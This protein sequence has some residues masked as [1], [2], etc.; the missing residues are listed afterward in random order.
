MGSPSTT[1]WIPTILLARNFIPAQ[2][3]PRCR[4]ATIP[5]VERYT[6]YT[7]G[8]IAHTV[9]RMR[10]LVHPDRRSLDALLVSPRVERITWE[11]AQKLEYRPVS[12]GERFG[13]VWA[14]F[15]FRLQARVPPEWA[16][17]QVDLIWMT[18]NESLL[19]LDGRAAQGLVDAGG[20][21]RPVATL[22]DRANGAER[23]D[24]QIELACNW[25]AGEP[26]SRRPFTEPRLERA[27]I[28]R[29]DHDAWNLLHDFRT[30]Q[31]LEADF[32]RGLDPAW[33]GELLAE[34]NRFCN[35]W[36]ADDRETWPQA[37]AILEQ[38]LQRRNGTSAHQV[39]AIGHGHLDTAWLW[40]LAETYRKS[41]RT[42]ST[43]LALMRSHPEH[44]F[45]S[46]AAQHYDWVKERN[47]G[48]YRRIVD[49]V[50]QGRWVPVG[51]T[52]I[53]PDCNIPSGESLVRQFLHGQRYFEA[54][55]G[56]RC[57]EFWNPD[58]FGY[59]NQLPQLMQK[60]GITRFL[61]QK[62]AWNR[63]TQPQHHSFMWEGL[64]GSRVLSH[65]PPIDMGEHKVTAAEL[66]AGAAS[67]IDHGSASRA[68][69]MFGHSDGGGG[70][71]SEMLETLRRVGDLQGVPRTVLA[72]SDEFFDALEQDAA[73]LPVVVGELYL[74]LHRGTYTTQGAIKRGN[75]RCEAVLHDA[76]FLAAAVTRLAARPYPQAELE[77]LWK[78]LLVN[79]FHDILPGCSIPQVHAEAVEDF[80][81]VEREADRLRTE[82]V[83]ALVTEDSAAMVPVNTIGA[84]R[85]EVSEDPTGGLAFVEAASY[86]VGCY[87]DA[88]EP[89]RLEE[90]DGGFVL[91][92]GRLIVRLAL[93]G[94]V[95]S[96]TSGLDG[97]E[98][99]AAPGNRFEL[100]DD[101]P[102][103][104]DAWDIDPFHLETGKTLAG[105][106]RAQVSRSEPLRA[107]V[108]FEHEI[109]RGSRLVQKVRLDAGAVRVDFETEVHW[110][111]RHQLLKVAFPLLVRA[112][113]AT[114]ETAFGHTERPTHYTTAAD[115]ARYE[116]PAH[117]WAD[118]SEHGFGVALLNDCK[119][120]YSAFGDTL[121]LSLLRAPTVPD[122]ESD[123]GEHRFTYSLYPH[124]GTWREGGVIA[125]AQ[126][127][128]A[129][130]LWAPGRAAP[131]SLAS[132][133]DPNVVLDS[134]KGAEDGPSLVLRLYESHGA[135]GVARVR[136][137]LP[138]TKVRFANL[139]EEPGAEA[140]LDAGK[141]EV[142]YEPYEVITLLVE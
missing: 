15:W 108:T 113:R 99:L 120:G 140:T 69:M 19:W 9:E 139:L 122:P 110:H 87:A 97:R 135:R 33:A 72:T 30:L 64:D 100:Y 111:E 118:M 35:I 65:F 74:E 21:H 119:Y 107:E 44:R 114:Y 105:A 61:T 7:R 57:R 16:G 59:T 117:R 58:A 13:P 26:N 82:A 22:L 28:A 90:H 31:E 93:D 95:T 106:N 66:R 43:Q 6:E 71:T 50:R 137:G 1:S 47:P 3:Q 78:R 124:H 92:N 131:S 70:P 34:L 75:R 10:E 49:Q 38:L 41:E 5:P 130:L 37:A 53:E 24:A 98:A 60:A 8:R 14:T 2:S 45:A 42:F 88:P 62:L 20:H 128:N 68:M 40:P 36:D 73:E 91:A 17:S 86:G 46:S 96:V 81:Y 141:V 27:E 11:D 103:R 18:G 55:F 121:R 133:D 112:E 12:V 115:L 138:F 109:G 77:R 67:F 94:T 132:V 56:R 76:E 79:Q 63:F 136:L 127:L 129:P 29:F 54:E 25:T 83:A 123:Q 134:I 126:R 4:P 116:V 125:E 48:L 89:V 85:R 80:A 142:P 104:Y 32:G 84:G 51:G 23:I 39:F 52:W 101:R 102:L